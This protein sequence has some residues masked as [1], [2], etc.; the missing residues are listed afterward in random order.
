[1]P[2]SSLRGQNSSNYVRTYHPGR[3][4]GLSHW[5]PLSLNVLRLM[6]Q[7]PQISFH[8]ASASSSTTFPASRHKSVAIRRRRRNPSCPSTLEYLEEH[9]PSLEMSLHAPQLQFHASSATPSAENIFET[10]RLDPAM[11]ESNCLRKRH[12]RTVVGAK[13]WWFV[14]P[15]GR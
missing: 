15:G 5:L 7:A 12:A 10:R 14:W 3:R 6:L 8:H 11:L 4:S 9:F 1:M 2:N 13:L